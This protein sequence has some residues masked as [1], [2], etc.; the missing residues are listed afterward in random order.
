MDISNQAR[1]VTGLEKEAEALESGERDFEYELP[2]SANP[3][4]YQFMADVLRTVADV[5]ENAPHLTHNELMQYMNK[6]NER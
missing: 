1:I 5:I 6:E 3:V 4:P 2:F